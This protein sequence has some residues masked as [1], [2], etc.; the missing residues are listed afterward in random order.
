L[1]RCV[2]LFPDEVLAHDPSQFPQR[3]DVAIPASIV[4]GGDIDAKKP[5]VRDP[6]GWLRLGRE[7]RGEERRTRT[8]EERAAVDHSIT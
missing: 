4:K 1:A 7:R 3:R 6:A 8:S 5:E 2:P